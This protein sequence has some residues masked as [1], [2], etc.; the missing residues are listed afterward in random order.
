MPHSAQT[1][2]THG[3]KIVIAEPLAAGGQLHNDNTKATSDALDD[4]DTAIAAKASASALAAHTSN[5]SNPHGVTAAQVGAYST[6]AA[7]TLLAAKAAAAITISTTAPLAGGGDLSTTRTLSITAATTSA[8]GSMSASD[9]TKLDGIA[10]GASVSSV[11]LSLPAI[12]NVTGTPVT[13]SGTLT[14]ALA[15]QIANLVFA[16]PSTGVAA[17]PTFRSLVAADIPT[18]PQS[19]ITNLTTDLAAKATLSFSTIAITG[20]GGQSNVVADN[21]ADTLT[22]NA[23]SNIVIN[24]TAGSDIIAF[25]LATSPIISNAEITTELYVSGQLS[26]GG[27][28]VLVGSSDIDFSVANSVTVPD[29]YTLNIS[30]AGTV[31]ASGAVCG[32]VVALTDGATINTDAHLGNTFTVT[33]GGNRTMAAPTNVATGQKIVYRIK[34]DGTGSRT[35]TW[36]AAFRFAGGTAPTLTTTA[37]KTDYIGFIYNA[38]DSKWDCVAERLNF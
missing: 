15:T 30:V 31:I 4:V 23:G 28:L 20:T 22:F 9:K 29:L 19:Q 17:A 12:F 3:H 2:G 35:L 18:L 10:A 38:A 6:S 21:N 26:L 24:S 5:T 7:D 33:L 1:Y 27:P 34:Q 14:A 25:A 11:G 36:N 13:S 16:G 32:G 8:A 37:A